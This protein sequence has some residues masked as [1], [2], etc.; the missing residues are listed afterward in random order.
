MFVVCDMF[1]ILCIISDM[2]IHT[3]LGAISATYNGEGN[4]VEKK[5]S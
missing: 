5:R 2:Y 4:D 3:N 1:I